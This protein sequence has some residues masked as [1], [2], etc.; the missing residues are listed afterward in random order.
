M[1]SSVLQRAKT[2]IFIYLY[3]RKSPWRVPL[4]CTH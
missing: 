3:I 2:W 1:G 4:H